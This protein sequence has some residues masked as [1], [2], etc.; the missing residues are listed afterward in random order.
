MLWARKEAKAAE[1][2]SSGNQLT[3]AMMAAILVVLGVPI[4]CEVGI[5]PA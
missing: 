2:F 3:S 5:G 1:T 4:S